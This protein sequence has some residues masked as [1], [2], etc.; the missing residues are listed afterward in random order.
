MFFLKSAY[1]DIYSLI[2]STNTTKTSVEQMLKFV[3]GYSLLKV[4]SS[5]HF[6]C[7]L[8]ATTT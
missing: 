4:Q 8:K 1:N 7:V 2:S 5:T 3:S 6:P